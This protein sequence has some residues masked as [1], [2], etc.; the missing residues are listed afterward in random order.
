MK[1]TILIGAAA[2]VLPLLG[3]T[4]TAL[5]AA[6]ERQAV[7]TGTVEWGRDF[8]GAL[9]ESER[10]GKPVLV[11]FQE[12][13]GCAGCRQ[14]GREVLTHPVIVSAMESE[15]IP[16]LVYNNRPGRDA[17]ILERYGEPVWNYQVIRFL[18]GSGKDIIPRRDRVWAVEGVAGRM[19]EVLEVRGREVPR[20][21]R[22]LVE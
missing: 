18:D 16:V 20:D 13:P 2:L 6:T 12:V 1:H 9:E 11:L 17:E 4:G 22:G 14:F 8:E 3:V 10:S 5:P 15:F 21:L 7:E 19:V